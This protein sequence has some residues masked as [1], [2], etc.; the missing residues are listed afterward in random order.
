MIWVGG[1]VLL[2]RC[3]PCRISQL[4]G[5]LGAFVETQTTSGTVGAAV[6]I[7]G[8]NLTGATSD[9]FNGTAATFAVVSAAEIKATAPTGATMGLVEGVTLGGTLKSNK[10][11]TETP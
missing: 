6:K 1:G 11:F 4:F 9:P 10:Q 3:E 7:L 8:N 5:G 2:S